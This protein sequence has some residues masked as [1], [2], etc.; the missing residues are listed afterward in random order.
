MNHTGSGLPALLGLNLQFGATSVNLLAR[1]HFFS[2]GSSMENQPGCW[3]LVYS[4]WLYYMF[5]WLYFEC[6]FDFAT[7]KDV[8]PI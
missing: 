5:T 2:N 3:S 1:P 7:T 4:S 6:G 8:G